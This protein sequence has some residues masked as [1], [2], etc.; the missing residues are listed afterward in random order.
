MDR[1]R[2]KRTEIDRN[3]KKQTETNRNGQKQTETYRN[4]RTPKK[5]TKMDINKKKQTEEKKKKK[6]ILFYMSSLT[7]HMSHVTCPMSPVTV[8]NTNRHS[9]RPFPW[10]LY[11][12][13]I[14]MDSSENFFLKA[15]GIKTYGSKSY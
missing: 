2:Q 11:I 3:L 1:T 15:I 7:C 9:Q 4:R 14:F 10:R 12:Y 5:Q 8:T 6:Y 13:V